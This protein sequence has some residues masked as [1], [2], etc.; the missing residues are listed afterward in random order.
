M[1]IHFA[2]LL[3]TQ[4]SLSQSFA[5]LLRI[6]SKSDELTEQFSRNGECQ[7]IL[8][9]NG[10]TLLSKINSFVNALQTLVTKTMEDTSMTIKAYEKAR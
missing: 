1:L 3:Q 4:H 10:D 2:G 7:Q 6:S 9:Q 5:N 8:A